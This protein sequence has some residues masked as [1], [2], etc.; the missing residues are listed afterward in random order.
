MSRDGRTWSPWG[1][2][3]ARR[4]EERTALEPHSLKKLKHLPAECPTGRPQGFQFRSSSPAPGRREW[5]PITA[6]VGHRGPL[7]PLPLLQPR[8]FRAGPDLRLLGDRASHSLA[9]CTEPT[10][11][12]VP[13]CQVPQAPGMLL[14]PLL[15]NFDLCGSFPWILTCTAHPTPGPLKQHHTL[16]A[17]QKLKARVW[18]PYVPP[19]YPQ[20]LRGVHPVTAVFH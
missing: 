2:R 10:P 6:S 18:F 17:A 19:H 20:C 9:R 15:L 8:S 5:T 16:H 14:A 12:L 1:R 13:G 4:E 11:H 3:E 7:S